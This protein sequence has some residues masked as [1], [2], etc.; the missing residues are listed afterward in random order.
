MV[1]PLGA[2]TF[3]SWIQGTGMNSTIEMYVHYFTHNLRTA[4][5][6]GHGT[7]VNSVSPRGNFK[8]GESFSCNT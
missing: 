3:P 2:K 1:L 8:T 4:F 6:H 7:S 5:R